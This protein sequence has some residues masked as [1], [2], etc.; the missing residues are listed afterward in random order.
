MGCAPESLADFCFKLS[1]EVLERLPF[2]KAV[3]L[4]T[5]ELQ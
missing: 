1:G 3:S 4:G 2:D 5:S